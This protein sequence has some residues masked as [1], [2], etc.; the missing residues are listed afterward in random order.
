MEEY[1]SKKGNVILDSVLFLIVLV[2][3]GIVGV[4]A[5]ITFNDMADDIQADA[6]IQEIAKNETTALNDRF[7]ST[8]DGAFALMFG[9]LWLAVLVT[10]FMI[11]SHPIFFIA[12]IIL[13][14]ILLA[15]SGMISNAY[16][17]FSA[18]AEFSS[19]AL[20]FPITSYILQNLLMFVLIIGATI[21][22]ALFGKSR[23]G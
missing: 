5:A 2:V 8:L 16:E 4:L 19:M 9:L 11:D 21:A 13:L 18:D 3:F 17:E 1:G 10:S 20:E 14:I 7:P 12:S 23:F 22:V 15:A 6:D